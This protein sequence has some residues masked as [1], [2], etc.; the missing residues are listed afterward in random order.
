[1]LINRDKNF[2][3]LSNEQG[4]ILLVDL[5]SENSSFVKDHLIK[6]F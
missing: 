1:M 5:H 3:E 4:D 2:C 6:Y